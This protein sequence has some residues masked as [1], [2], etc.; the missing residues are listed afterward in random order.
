MDVNFELHLATVR[1]TGKVPLACQQKP[2]LLILARDPQGE[3]VH[4]KV[5]ARILPP[6]DSNWWVL[7]AYPEKIIGM[8]MSDYGES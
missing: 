8:V 1:F 2:K 3:K 4:F 7:V 6:E 5:P